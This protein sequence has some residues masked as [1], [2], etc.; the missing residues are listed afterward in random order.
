MTT[1]LSRLLEPERR[2]DPGW[3]TR[4]DG[5]ETLSPLSQPS[6]VLVNRASAM[7]LSTWWRCVDLISS[8]VSLAPVSVVVRVGSRSFPEYGLPAW[9]SNPDPRDPNYMASDYFGEATLSMLTD[10][11]FFTAVYPSVLDPQVLILLDP[12]LVT[13]R[14]G[15]LYDIRDRRSGR[16]VATLDPVQMLHG[17]W[18]RLPGEL[19]GVS[20][21]EALRRGI[22]SAIAADEFAGRFFGQGAAL[23]F[24][25]EVPPEP[26]GGPMPKEKKEALRDD[27]TRRHA[28]VRNSHM[29]GVLTGGAKFVTGLGP[30]PEQAQMLETRKFGVEDIARIFGVPPGMAGSQQPGASSYASASEWRQ[31]FRDDSVLKFTAKLERQHG[32]LLSVPPG[33]SDP[34]ARAEVSFDLDWVARANLLDRYQAHGEAVTKG[35]RTP[36]EVR[37]DEGEAP[38]AGGDRLY[39][40][41]QMVP[42]EDLGKTKLTEPMAGQTP[43]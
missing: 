5:L 23:A 24:G 3:L 33:I 21:L 11:N 13:V 34:N 1:I 37:H 30:T 41:Q 39:M 32:R 20:P 2:N 25:V 42:L 28:G 38:L 10:G 15:P 17:W 7:S 8:T 43:A 6:G 4:E 9:L 16:V 14:K 29:I 19:R 26:G 36:N 22:G 31:Q 12:A 40:Q 18:I 27:L 35:I